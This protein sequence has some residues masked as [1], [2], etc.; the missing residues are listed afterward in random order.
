MLVMVVAS[1]LAWMA[2]LA[3]LVVAEELTI[4]G[5]RITRPAAAILAA[6]A[7]STVTP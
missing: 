4:R 6:A 5:R 1:S 7:V 2:A 3:A